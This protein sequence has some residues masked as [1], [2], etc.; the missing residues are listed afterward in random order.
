MK[1]DTKEYTE[2]VSKK[3]KNKQNKSMSVGRAVILIGE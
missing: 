1:P 3:L 2:S